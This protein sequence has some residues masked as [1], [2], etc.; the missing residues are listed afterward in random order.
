MTLQEVIQVA[1]EVDLEFNLLRG[2]TIKLFQDGTFSIDGEL[3][4]GD[5]YLGVEHC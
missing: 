5:V 2:N 4:V 1:E 3:C